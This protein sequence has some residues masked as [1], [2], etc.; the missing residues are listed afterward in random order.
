MPTEYGDFKKW[1]IENHR[2]DVIEE[3]QRAYPTKGDKVFLLW[4]EFERSL[5][6]YDINTVINWRWENLYLTEVSLGNQ[7]FNN[8]LIDTQL[9]DIINE[10][11]TKWISSIPIPTRPAYDFI[12]SKAT[13]LTFNYTDTLEQLYHVPEHQILHIHGRASRR[14]KLIVG[15]NQMIDP[16]EYWDD[17]LDVR[18]N[19]ERMQRLMD[20]NDL[21]KPVYEIMSRNE[22]F[23]QGLYTVHDVH[24]IGHS[25]DE[26]DYPYFHKVKDSVSKDVKWHFNPHQE[27]DAKNMVRLIDSIGISYEQTTGINATVYMNNHTAA[28]HKAR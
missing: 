22:A 2:R 1:L 7:L 27:K 14:E 18:E 12:T 13:Y 25:C 23:F 4:S 16:S 9:P 28:N 19:N 15:H 6:E 11:F 5:G 26:I 20:M 3:L 8:N 17:K 24:I 10:S 21:C